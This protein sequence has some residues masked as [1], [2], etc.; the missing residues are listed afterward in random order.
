M[1]LIVFGDPGRRLTLTI[2]EQLSES[3]T[4][5]LESAVEKLVRYGEQ[6]GV[7]PEE[8]IALLDSGIGIR[9][10]LTFLASKSWSA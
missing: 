6:V 9:E 2:R 10:L 4:K 1:I 8:M 3:G 7:T 5:L